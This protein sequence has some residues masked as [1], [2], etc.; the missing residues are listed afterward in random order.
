MALSEARR[1]YGAR[2][3]LNLVESREAAVAGADALVICTE[4]KQ[5]STVDFNWLY[6]QLRQPVIV[7]GRNLYNPAEVKQHGFLYYAI[8]R[9]DSL[10]ARTNAMPQS[11]GTDPPIRRV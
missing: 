3:D 9:G 1:L 6:R 8:G 4:W 10:N 11:A 7:D 2:D 5:F